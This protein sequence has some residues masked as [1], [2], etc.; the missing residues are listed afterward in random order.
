MQRTPH[1]YLRNLLLRFFRV[2]VNGTFELTAE[3]Q[4]G[5]VL[6]AANHVSYLDGIIVALASP[7]PLVIPPQIQRP[8]K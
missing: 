7:F 6:I 1:S 8:E 5:R 4:Q 2:R 3:L